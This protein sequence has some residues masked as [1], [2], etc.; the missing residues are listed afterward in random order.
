LNF[1]FGFV[2]R[3]HPSALPSIWL[4]AVT[5]YN[6]TT[7]PLNAEMAAPRLTHAARQMLLASKRRI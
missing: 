4:D 6:S 7:A 1:S 3:A 2:H 5:P